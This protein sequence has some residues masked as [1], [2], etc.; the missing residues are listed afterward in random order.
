MYLA[1]PPPSLVGDDFY[2]KIT[3]ATAAQRLDHMLNGMLAGFD[4]DIVGEDEWA[5]TF[6][7]ITEL[8][9]DRLRLESR[10]SHVP[11][12]SAWMHA[13]HSMFLVSCVY[14]TRVVISAY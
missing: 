5:R 9:G 10:P 7:W 3:T 2:A 11:W 1:I 14:W 6:W 12:L 13:A 4:V 8:L